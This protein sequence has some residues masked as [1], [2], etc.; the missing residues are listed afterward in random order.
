ML[1]IYDKAMWH[2]DGGE[3][4]EKVLERMEVVLKFLK[5]HDMLN[6]EGIEELEI[7]VDSSCSIHERMLTDYGRSFLDKYYDSFLVDDL[8]VVQ[9]LMIRYYDEF[10]AFP[11]KNE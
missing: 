6:D 3:Q 10:K 1:K 4:K 8:D 9:Q 7:G 5:S 11:E 2:I